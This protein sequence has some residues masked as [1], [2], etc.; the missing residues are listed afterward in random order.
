MVSS[1]TKLEEI[2]AVPPVDPN[3]GL[4]ADA[5]GNLYRTT[6]NGLEAGAD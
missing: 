4:V 3:S 5:S 6:R 2:Q 1:I